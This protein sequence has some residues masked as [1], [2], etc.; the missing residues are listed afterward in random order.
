MGFMTFSFLMRGLYALTTM[1]PLFILPLNL[2]TQCG[3]PFHY[4]DMN[5]LVI[6]FERI[7][8]VFYL[9]LWNNYSRRVKCKMTRRNSI[10]KSTVF[11]FMYFTAL[12]HGNWHVL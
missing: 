12:W 5:F 7:L 2:P 3:L 6:V 10:L 1:L 4:H 9:V 11:V 8:N